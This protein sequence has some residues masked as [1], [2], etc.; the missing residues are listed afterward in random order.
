MRVFD[1]YFDKPAVSGNDLRTEDCESLR[2]S[3]TTAFMPDIHPGIFINADLVSAGSQVSVRIVSAHKG[4]PFRTQIGESFLR[5]IDVRED[6]KG[7]EEDH[8]SQEGMFHGGII[9]HN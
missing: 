6:R 4:E 9:A 7:N 3:G 8:E 1:V 2:S 5:S